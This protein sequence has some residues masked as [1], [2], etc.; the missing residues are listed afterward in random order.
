MGFF[1]VTINSWRV[2]GP[3]RHRHVLRHALEARRSRH[4]DNTMRHALGSWQHHPTHARE[5]KGVGKG[6]VFVMGEDQI[7]VRLCSRILVLYTSFMPSIEMPDDFAD[8][9]YDSV[10]QRIGNALVHPQRGLC[11]MGYS[12]PHETSNFRSGTVEK[13]TRT[14]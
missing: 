4:L 8:D 6:H 14:A 11:E 9:L 5:G 2:R 3:S 1:Y 13:R 7:E 12:V 10:Y